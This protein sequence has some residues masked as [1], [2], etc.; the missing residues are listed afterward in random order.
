MERQKV[1]SNLQKKLE[2]EGWRL[3][4]NDDSEIDWISNDEGFSS[5]IMRLTPK[6]DGEL[7]NTYLE[8]GFE[9]VK[10]TKAYDIYGKL[11]SNYKGIYVK[12][13]PLRVS[14]LTT[15]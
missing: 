11:L 7:E 3:L 9:D 4:T 10:V 15:Q 12:G 1:K 5:P 8:R 14:K 13:Q 2:S 6:S